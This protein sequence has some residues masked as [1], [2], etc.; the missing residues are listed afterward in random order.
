[1][2][3]DQTSHQKPLCGTQLWDFWTY[4]VPTNLI[5]VRCGVFV[6]LV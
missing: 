5:S 2:K 3:N 6:T 4:K 1:M